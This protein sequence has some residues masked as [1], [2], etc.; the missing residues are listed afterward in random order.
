LDGDRANRLREEIL[1][2]YNV[3]EREEDGSTS[4]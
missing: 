4:E 2:A 1:S 3:E